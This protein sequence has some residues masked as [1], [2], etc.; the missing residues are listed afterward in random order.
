MTAQAQIFLPDE[1]F[2]ELER[3]APKLEARSSLITEALRYFFATHDNNQNAELEQLNQ[4][5]DELN[6][7]A[8]DVLSYQ[9][10][11]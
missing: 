9:V 6:E 2:Y 4:Y 8:E 7:E 10:M 5:A 3:R 11:Q 1:I